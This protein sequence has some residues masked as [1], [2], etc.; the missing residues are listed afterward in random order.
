MRVR[1]AC[2][3]SRSS[4]L[5]K[6]PGNILYVPS[7]NAS[8][9]ARPSSG[10]TRLVHRRLIR[11]SGP[12]SH[13]FLQGLTTNNVRPLQST[14]HYSAFL[15]AQGRVLYDVFVY[16]QR[17]G[18]EEEGGYMIECDASQVDN[19]YKHLRRYKLRA[20]VKLQKLEEGEQEVWQ[21]WGEDGISSGLDDGSIAASC[22]DP[23]APSMGKRIIA[24]RSGSIGTPGAEKDPTSP[25]AYT[26]HRYLH[27]VA[28]GQS[29]I[30]SGTA[31][32]QESN[33]DLMG[34]I[35]FRKGCYVGQE[36]TIR[37]HHTGV[38]RKRILPV[39]LYDLRD[40]KEVEQRT[41][42]YDPNSKLRAPPAGTN[43]SHVGRKGRSAGSWLRAPG[44]WVWRC[45]GWR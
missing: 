19:V 10:L 15:N 21:A 27:G 24:A 35:D 5:A 6:A 23:R 13:K 3:Q 18:D 34:G 20:A 12:E 37:T 39:L 38:V 2:C 28:E 11:L 41:L 31:L 9:V 30:Q 1:N 40:G 32:P 43:I 45:V 36:L 17:L 16:P 29:E 26:V 22:D 7:R 33:I 44:T 25:S 8:T 4:P 14:P 42:E